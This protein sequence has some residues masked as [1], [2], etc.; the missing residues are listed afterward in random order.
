MRRVLLAFLVTVVCTSASR[1][2]EPGEMLS[3]PAL[4]ARARDI[5]AGLRCLVC[6][7]Q[8]IDDSEASL[9]RDLRHLVRERLRAGD[10]DRQVRDYLVARY[11]SY[12]LL[13]PPFELATSLLWLTPLVCLAGGAVVMI[14][15][16]RR[17]V[18]RPQRV[19]LE[20]AEAAAVE[21]IVTDARQDG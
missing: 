2:V 18:S 19:A 9:A 20:P 3:N 10:S 7:N 4:E 1:A 14:V 11:G 13:K 5:S 16:L 12:I 6:Q 8:S 21:R 15:A 17:G